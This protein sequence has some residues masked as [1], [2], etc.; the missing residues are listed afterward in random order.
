MPVNSGK[1]ITGTEMKSTFIAA[2]CIVILMFPAYA[3]QEPSV[4]PSFSHYQA[5]VASVKQGA[6]P[7]LL[8]NQDREFK[9][10]LVEASKHNVNFAGH[11]VLSW[12]GCGAS[13]IMAFALD[14]NSGKVSWLPFT[15]CCTEA[16]D[17]QAAPLVFKKDS[18]LVVVTGSRNEQGK[19]VYFYEFN[20]GQYV[21]LKELER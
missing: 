13:C 4:T 10:R 5:A 7:K 11:Y 12:F 16:V 20:Q 14:K 18:R 3:A 19:G 1:N 21:L 9:T 8:S 17:A 15:V 2:A 6:K